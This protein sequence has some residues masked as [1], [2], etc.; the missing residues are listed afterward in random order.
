MEEQ[1]Q[2]QGQTQSLK[3]PP[4]A[5]ADTTLLQT[6]TE[7]LDL[8]YLAFDAV[9]HPIEGL[10]AYAPYA[11]LKMFGSKNFGV[12]DIPNLDGK[13]ILVTGGML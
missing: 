8:R 10:N 1:D 13:V 3:R 7:L 2:N 5:Q 4:R 11:N 6:F 9:L 12:T